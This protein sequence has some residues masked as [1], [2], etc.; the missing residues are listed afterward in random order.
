MFTDYDGREIHSMVFIPV[1]G[2]SKGIPGK[3]LR[4]LGGKSLLAHTVEYALS[5]AGIDKVVVSTDDEEIRTESVH[6][7]AQAPFVR[8]KELG[9]DSALLS[10]AYRHAALWLE[11]NEHFTPR[12][13]V[14]MLCTNPFRRKGLVN[15]AVRW[16]LEEPKLH[17]VNALTKITCPVDNL[18]FVRNDCMQPVFDQEAHMPEQIY[19]FSGSFHVQFPGRDI[20]GRDGKPSPVLRRGGVVLDPI[21]AIDLDELKDLERAREI[22]ACGAHRPPAVSWGS[23]GVCFVPRELAPLP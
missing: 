1:R 17:S 10:D 2:G 15:A 21:E 6:L 20:C 13:L 12:V 3:A 5:I 19:A 9:T 8:P 22:V 4:D 18:F 16:G 11:E 14:T 23:P 7:G